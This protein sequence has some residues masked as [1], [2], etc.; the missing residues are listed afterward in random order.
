MHRAP[1][2]S[3]IPKV[4]GILAVVFA[5][6]GLLFSLAFSLGIDHEME[7]FSDLG[8]GAFSVWL[9]V[10][11]VVS[12]MIFLIHL[13]AGIMSIR[14]SRNA[15]IVMTL[16]GALALLF[17]IV[18]IAMS[19]ATVPGGAES[20][21]FSEL[22]APRIG[23]AVFAFPWPIVAIVLSNVSAARRACGRIADEVGEVFR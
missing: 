11:L 7:R 4:V 1:S 2:R 19:I 8:L 17:L 3:A 15:P 16:Y 5:P 14:Y 20:F 6:I 10:S 9:K 12:A 22:V 18:D 23:L 13:T 21:A